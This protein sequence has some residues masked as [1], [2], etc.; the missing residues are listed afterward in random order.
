MS[1]DHVPLNFLPGSTWASLRELCGH[2]EQSVG[3]AGTVEAIRLF[4]RLL[5][6]TSGTDMGPGKARVLTAADRDR[7]LAAIYI[8]TYGSRIAGTVHCNNCDAPFDIDFSLEKL[9]SHIYNGTNQTNVEK[10]H[11]GAFRL[12]DGHRFRLPTGEDEC[13]ILGMSPE[14]AERE[15]LRRCA[16]EGDP[17]GDTE[18]LQ[19]TMKDLAPLLDLDLEAHCPECKRE[20]MVHFDI[21][22]YLFSALRQEQK[23]LALE[24]H[25]LATAYG[26]SLNEILQLPRSSRR[27]YV[28]LVESELD[29]ST[30]RP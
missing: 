9:L 14:E 12:P 3:E 29:S 11:D 2:D 24:V 25:R 5:V 7:L 22:H 4:D 20:Q 10:E 30:G 6:A 8:H 17:T 15:L 28:A 23:Q 27:T 18:S 1:I 16:L 19:R 26:W 13:V 21:Q